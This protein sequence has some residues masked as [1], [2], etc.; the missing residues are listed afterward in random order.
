MI[1]DVCIAVGID[2]DRILGATYLNERGWII[3]LEN[4]AIAFFFNNC[5]IKF[6]NRE[7]VI[8]D[9]KLTIFVLEEL[10]HGLP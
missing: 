3:R 1:V 2:P 7:G 4:E 9:V 5:Y 6:S 8:F 10:E